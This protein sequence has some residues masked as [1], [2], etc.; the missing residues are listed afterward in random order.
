M[1][2]LAGDGK[3][4]TRDS[5]VEIPALTG[6]PPPIKPAKA[7]IDPDRISS[8]NK[9]NDLREKRTV[10]LSRSQ[11]RLPRINTVLTYCS[12]TFENHFLDERFW[13][14]LV[15]DNLFGCLYPN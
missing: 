6:W 12:V 1:G 8:K 4:R 3:T 7:P 15:H 2:K 14:L 5:K 13:S 9:D 10:I 11:S